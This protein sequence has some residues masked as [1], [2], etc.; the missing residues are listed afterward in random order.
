MPLLPLAALLIVLIQP[1]LI[2]MIPIMVFIIAY[3]AAGIAELECG[4]L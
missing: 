4:E 2:Y 1:D 3:I